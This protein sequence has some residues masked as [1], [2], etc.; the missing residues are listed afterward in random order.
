MIYKSQLVPGL[1]GGVSLSKT[2]YL[3]FKTMDEITEDN[4]V[5]LKTIITNEQVNDRVSLVKKE[6]IFRYR[7]RHEIYNITLIE[8]YIDGKLVN[9]YSFT[10]QV[11]DDQIPDLHLPKHL[12]KRKCNTQP[13]PPP[14]QDKPKTDRKEYLKNYNKEYYQKHK[15]EY[16]EKYELK[17]SNY[18]K[19]I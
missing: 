17:K 15:D 11:D 3:S 16:K 7:R 8:K 5:K 9:S 6:L 13:S 19:K 2:R 18:G 10:T 4:I 1:K 14:P 12:C